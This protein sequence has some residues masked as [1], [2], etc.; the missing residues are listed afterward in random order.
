MTL[1]LDHHFKDKKLL[2][3]ALTHTSAARK[4]S[5]SNER[6][7]FLGDRVLNMLVAEL[8]CDMFPKEN[9]GDL[10]RRLT[11]LVCA[12]ALQDIALEI[13][14]PEAI[15]L[16]GGEASS[17]GAAKMNVLADACEALV[18]AL[19]LD[20]GLDAA[21]IFIQKHW[22]ERARADLK[23]VQDAKS[24]LQEWAQGRGLPLPVYTIL[25]RSGP[26][27]APVFNVSVLVEGFDAATGQG[28]NKREAEKAAAEALLNNLIRAEK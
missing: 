12:P 25:E 17:G 28:A 2:N 18:A 9:E 14:L 7:E 20:G 1:L 16:S 3:Q 13:N 6:L 5:E 19:Y 15:R 8:I 24:A 23:P 21:R 27:H 4:S 26:D 11:N 22:T 10:A